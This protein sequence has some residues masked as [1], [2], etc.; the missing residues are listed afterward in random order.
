MVHTLKTPY[1]GGKRRN[2]SVRFQDSQGYPLRPRFQNKTKIYL[3][4]QLYHTNLRKAHQCVAVHMPTE[5]R[6][7][8]SLL[9]CSGPKVWQI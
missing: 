6:L 5:H 1:S 4:F 3:T 9:K 7:S 2:I 8:L